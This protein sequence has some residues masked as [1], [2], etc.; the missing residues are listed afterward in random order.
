MLSRIH[1]HRNS[2]DNILLM[3]RSC[4]SRQRCPDLSEGRT[5]RLIVLLDRCPSEYAFQPGVT[6]VSRLH[7]HA[8]AHTHTHIMLREAEGLLLQRALQLHLELFLRWV[9]RKVQLQ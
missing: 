6:A 3:F 2:L 8:R 4:L 9:L 1:L 5:R 7:W